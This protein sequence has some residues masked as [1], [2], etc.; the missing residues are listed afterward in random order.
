VAELTLKVNGAPQNLIYKRFRTRSLWQRLA[1]LF[2]RTKCMRSW[3]LGNA[4]VDCLLP[5]ALP[6]AAFERRRFGLAGDGYMLMEKIERVVDL[7]RA[8][9]Q[10]ND[11]NWRERRKALDS[12][13]RLVARL[14]RQLHDRGWSH[15]DLKAGNIL[16]SPTG[17]LIPAPELRCVREESE[18][19][20]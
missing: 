7:R 9:D 12:R 3:L 16:V 1:S 13:S 4:F 2:R 6:L 5:T 19:D 17:N 10:L 20:S 18:C 14:V 15:R 8:V 11:L